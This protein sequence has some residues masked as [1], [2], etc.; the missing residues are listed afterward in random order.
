[1]VEHAVNF[2]DEEAPEPGGKGEIDDLERALVRGE[3][4]AYHVHRICAL[5]REAW[6]A[7]REA[8]EARAALAA[9]TPK[10]RETLPDE[11]WKR[12]ASYWMRVAEQG[13][14]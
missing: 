2:D 14:G 10:E 4:S 13:H 6:Q 7:K 3:A 5:A 11:A 8:A 9:V 12:A 1:M